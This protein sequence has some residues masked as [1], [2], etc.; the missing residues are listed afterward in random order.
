MDKHLAKAIADLAIFLE[1]TDPE[2][3]DEDVAIQAMEQL[4]SE[5]QLM[6]GDMR[7]RLSQ[8]LIGLATSY[9]GPAKRHFVE[10]LPDALGLTGA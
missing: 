6:D 1:F 3:L 5:L 10:Q 4:A 9:R 7:E 8:Q 2:L